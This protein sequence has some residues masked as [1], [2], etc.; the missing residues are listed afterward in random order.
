MTALTSISE[1]SNNEEVSGLYTLHMYMYYTLNY[2]MTKT[3]ERAN[4]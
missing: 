2:Y 4:N 1:K 3:V